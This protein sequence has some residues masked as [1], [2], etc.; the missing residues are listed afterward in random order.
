[1][2][3]LHARRRARDR[4]AGWSATCDASSACPARAARRGALDDELRFHL[5]GRIEELMEREASLAR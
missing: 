4:R 5:E 3:A 2:V 1:M